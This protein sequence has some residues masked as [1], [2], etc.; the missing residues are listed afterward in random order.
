MFPVTSSALECSLIRSYCIIGTCHARVFV[1]VLK[2]NG[3]IENWIW[4]SEL[5]IGIP[6][7]LRLRSIS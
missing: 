6:F 2:V 4:F 7:Y 3:A 5:E 1:L